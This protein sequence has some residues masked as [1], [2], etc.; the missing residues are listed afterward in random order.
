[1]RTV[2]SALAALA[3]TSGVAAE[4]GEFMD[5]VKKEVDRLNA[6]ASAR[7][8]PSLVFRS[9]GAVAA[10]RPRGG[11]LLEADT[12]AANLGAARLSGRVPAILARIERELDAVDARIGERMHVLDEDNDGVISEEELKRALG[13]L[14]ESLG[15][16]E[17]RTLLERLQRAKVGGE[18]GN[19]GSGSGS[20]GSGSSSEILAPFPGEMGGADAS[21]SSGAA[22]SAADS[23]SSSSSSATP[24]AAATAASGFDVA[25]LM[26]LA[27]EESKSDDG[28][29]NAEKKV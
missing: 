22:A 23:S 24:L 13:F 17:L 18:G 21:T 6:E 12:S 11:G 1:M 28:A 15:E 14:R 8:A 25:H 10:E 3:S 27:A 4:R 5:L 20:G 29:E 9:S 2:L 7:G 16:D 19:A 26:Q